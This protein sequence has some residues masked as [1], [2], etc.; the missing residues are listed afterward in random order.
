VRKPLSL[1]KTAVWVLVVMMEDLEV[2]GV[3]FVLVEAGAGDAGADLEG[4]GDGM[5]RGGGGG[6]VKDM[7]TQLGTEMVVSLRVIVRGIG[8]WEGRIWFELLGGLEVNTPG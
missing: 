5:S 1:V 7:S 2:L 4:Y 3:G 8:G 6:G